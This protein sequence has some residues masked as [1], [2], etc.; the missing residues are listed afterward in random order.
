MYRKLCVLAK[1]FNT[2]L[3]T[4]H[5]ERLSIEVLCDFFKWVHE[6]HL[7]LHLLSVHWVFY[8]WDNVMNLNNIFYLLYLKPFD[9]VAGCFLVSI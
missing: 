1:P 6:I 8:Y 4:V 5:E 3:L 9:Q 7:T 2:R